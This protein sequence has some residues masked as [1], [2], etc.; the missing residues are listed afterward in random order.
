MIIQSL[1]NKNICLR[2]IRVHANKKSIKQVAARVSLIAFVTYYCTNRIVSS[3][4][5]GCYLR[6]SKESTRC[7]WTKKIISNYSQ[8][9][10]R[11]KVK[12]KM[13]LNWSVKRIKRKI[14]QISKV[15]KSVVEYLI[16]ELLCLWFHSI[17]STRIRSRAQ[18]YSVFFCNFL[19]DF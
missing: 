14:I 6:A 7:S 17:K 1:H 11:I 13:H 4:H 3:L 5:D 18:N 16:N 19:N 9:E 12:V 10:Q 8:I 2:L 15:C